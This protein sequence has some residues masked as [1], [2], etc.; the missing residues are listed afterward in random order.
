MDM[1]RLIINMSIVLNNKIE[2][3]GYEKSDYFRWEISVVFS[4]YWQGEICRQGMESKWEMVESK[5][6]RVES[7]QGWKVC[8]G[9]ICRQVLVE[10]KLGLKVCREECCRQVILEEEGSWVMRSWV[11]WVWVIWVW[12]VSWEGWEVYVYVC[13]I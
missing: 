13:V 3:N 10:S 7:K 2:V 11:I 8:M 12:V 9:V 5:W 6:V 1:K 4:I